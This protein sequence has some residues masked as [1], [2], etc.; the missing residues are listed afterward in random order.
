MQKIDH[1]NDQ[2]E[3]LKTV[4]MFIT[5]RQK[6]CDDILAL[7]KGK[8]TDKNLKLLGETI[9]YLDRTNLIKLLEDP[10]KQEDN[11]TMA[12][13]IVK[14]LERTNE[15]SPGVHKAILPNSQF[16]DKYNSVIESCRKL[17][18]DIPKKNTVDFKIF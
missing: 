4:D 9:L 17:W 10:S 11:K 14:L 5:H 7:M 13:N 8:M 16:S 6:L 15:F 2:E 1:P 18:Q 3:F 12:T